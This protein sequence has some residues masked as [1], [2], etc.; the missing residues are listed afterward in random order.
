[1]SCPARLCHA[2]P[3]S[4]SSE[5]NRHRSIRKVAPM[6]GV[7]VPIA[8][9]GFRDEL[10]GSGLGLGA[11]ATHPSYWDACA[12]CSACTYCLAPDRRYSCAELDVNPPPAKSLS[13]R[14]PTA[15]GSTICGTRRR[16]LKGVVDARLTPFPGTDEPT[17]WN[18]V[19]LGGT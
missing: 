1:M 9:P 6:S 12:I 14:S 8:A 4:P 17:T 10:K 11:H 13:Q 2:Q 7:P 15:R 16:E 5:R 19:V 18:S 3:L